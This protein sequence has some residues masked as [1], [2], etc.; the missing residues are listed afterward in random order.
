MNGNIANL[1]EEMFR[2][3]TESLFAPLSEWRSGGKPHSLER[4]RNIRRTALEM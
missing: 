3:W 2:W 1:E 4:N